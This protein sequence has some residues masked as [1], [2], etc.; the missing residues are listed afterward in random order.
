[1]S[2]KN[3]ESRTVFAITEKGDKSYWTRI[4][5]AFTNKDGSI[6]LEL[7]ALPVSGRLQIRDREEQKEPEERAD[8]RRKR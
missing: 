4:G 5:A 7:D 2:E 8:R 1:M 3:T 6:N